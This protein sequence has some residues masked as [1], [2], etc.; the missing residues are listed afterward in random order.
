[1]QHLFELA[2]P[3]EASSSAVVAEIRFRR[4][5]REITGSCAQTTSPSADNH[6][7]VSIPVAPISSAARNA[8]IVFSGSMR[9]APRWAKVMT[10]TTAHRAM[11]REPSADRRNHRAATVRTPNCPS[12]CDVVLRA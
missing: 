4:R 3:N 10:A 8:G 2:M 12:E 1:V 5:P 7:S 9:R 6:T 11:R